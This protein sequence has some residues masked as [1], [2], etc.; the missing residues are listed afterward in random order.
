MM[1]K[2]VVLAILDGWGLSE[3][4]T[5]NAIFLAQTPNMDDL[6]ARYSH[7]TLTAS[8]EAVGLPPGQQGNSEVGHLNLGAGRIVYQELTRI[9]KA[10]AEHTFEENKVLNKIMDGCKQSGHK[11]HLMGLL[12]PG[13]VHSHSDHLLAL[14]RMAEHKQLEK[15]YIHCFL[16]GR[17]VPPSSAKDYVAQLEEN[18]KQIGIGQIATVSG[19]YYAMDRDNRWERVEKAYRALTD[20]Q[21][22]Q[23]KSALSAIERSYEQGV[24]DEFVV[25]TVIVDPIGQPVGRITG[26]DGVIFFNFRSDRARELSK[27]F[28]S[29]AFDAFERKKLDVDFVGMT[30]YEEGLPIAVAFPPEDLTNTL[31]EVLANAGLRQFHTAETE[32]Y[33]HVTFFFNGGLEEAYPREERLLIPSPEIATYDLLPSMSAE[34]VTE[35]LLQAINSQA[36]DFLLVNYANADMVGHTGNFQA[37]VQAVET[38][39]KSIGQ[40]AEAVLAQDGVLCITADHGN[41][42]CMIATNGEPFTAHTANPVPFI[43][44]SR[45]EYTLRQGILADV[46]PTILNLLGIE[47]PKQMTGQSLI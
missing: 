27:C 36:Y 14:L 26:G 37:A 6:T 30:Q 31:G 39:D 38:V 16:D 21:G 4:Q 43:V 19:R 20:G 25:P 17:D 44:V 24:T 23:T 13:G 45:Q 1:K 35:G 8:G 28:V 34:Q 11:L 3:T 18:L 22:E 9:N 47:Q 15:V 46:A 5:G 42:E 40:I 10:I 32:K 29:A 41:A 33:A 7:T 12:S 2:P